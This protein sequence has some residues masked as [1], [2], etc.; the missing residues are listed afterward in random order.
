MVVRT[1]TSRTDGTLQ[2]PRKDPRNTASRYFIDN[3]VFWREPPRFGG[4][5][6][7][8]GPGQW[9]SDLPETTGV[10]VIVSGPSTGSLCESAISTHF[11]HSDIKPLHV[12]WADDVTTKVID[13][14][15]PKSLTPFAEAPIELWRQYLRLG[16]IPIRIQESQNPLTLWAGPT[17]PRLQLVE[18]QGAD[19]AEAQPQLTVADQIDPKE[20]LKQEQEASTHPFTVYAKTAIDRLVCES[21]FFANTLKETFLH[22]L[23]TTAIDKRTGKVVK[24]QARTDRVDVLEQ[25]R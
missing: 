20:W 5:D 8:H 2:E 16:D 23:S 1:T 15:I 17:T 21:R 22:P 6:P 12:F 7:L 18:A 14:N 25:P 3:V 4:D 19:S 9:L 10:V 24:Q 13:W 11:V